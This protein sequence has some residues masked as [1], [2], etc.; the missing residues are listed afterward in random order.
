MK[1]VYI[2]LGPHKTGT[3]SIQQACVK[4]RALLCSFGISYYEGFFPQGNHREIAACVLRDSLEWAGNARFRGQKERISVEVKARIKEHFRKADCLIVSAEALSYIRRQDELDALKD[5]FSTAD[6]LIPI[7]TRRDRASWLSSYRHQ[8]Q[9]KQGRSHSQNPDSAF[10]LNEDT[11][12]ANHDDLL[13]LLRKNFSDLI[14]LEY[15]SNMVEVF[16]AA[17]G[18]SITL[19]EYRI[20]VRDERKHSDK[21]F[22]IGFN[23]CGTSSL[24]AF[25]SDNGVSTLH[26]S[27]GNIGKRLYLNISA[28]LPVLTGM[29][30]FMAFSDMESTKDNIYGHR[31]FRE[32]FAEY[33]DSYYIL[34]TR[35][36]GNWIRSRL[37]HNNG[38]LLKIMKE[39]FGFSESQTIR[40]WSLEWDAHHAAV[41]DFYKDKGKFLVFDIEKD[42][43]QKL[44]EFLKPSFSFDPRLWGHYNKS[45]VQGP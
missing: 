19:P 29:S 6:R 26:W 5:L 4:S 41:T 25:F 16:T 21:I 32:I 39:N 24:A 15:Q 35:D 23:K 45:K 2:H 31:Y 22:Q 28:G 36:K 9:Q 33:P 38:L 10:N 18:L 3:T 27:R 12:L 40:Y 8:V 7:F 17:I 14:I 11:W 13:N 20:N 34:N 37:N 1:T 43:P 30:R 44:C 42:T